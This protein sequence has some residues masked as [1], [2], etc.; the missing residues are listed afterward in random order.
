M[1]A[2]MEHLRNLGIVAHIDAGKTTVT[3]RILFYAGVEHRMGEV[4]E[5]T[6]VMDWME[7][8][9]RRGIT[10]T[11]AA[12]SVP[13]RDCLINLIDTPGHVDFT[14][15][16]ERSMRVLDGAI[17]V[18]NAVA[19]VQAQSE[20]V[21][22]QMQAHHVKS[23]AFVN[24]VDRLGAD[25]LRCVKDLEERLGAPAVPIQLPVGSGR[26]CRTIVDLVDARAITF[27]EE[28]NARVPV[29]GP[30]PSEVADEVGVLRAELI[31]A[32]AEEDEAVMGAFLEE[33]EP[34]A[35][36]LRA[37]LRRRVLA[38]TLMPVLCGAAL[39][40]VGIQPL[41]EA[42][43]DYL[44]APEEVPPIRGL[45]AG[46]GQPVERPHDPDAPLCALAFKLSA[47]PHEDL[48]YTRVY[49]GRIRPGQK[50]FNPRVKRMERVARV[51]RMHA[52]AR[53][54]LEEAGPGQIVAL[55]G[56]K[57]TVTG[58]TLCDH[59]HALFLERVRFPKPVVSRVVEPAST[60]DRDRLRAALERLAFEDPSFHVREKEDTG[61]WLIAGMGE[62]HLEVKEHLLSELYRVSVHAGQPRVEYRETLRGRARGSGKVDRVLGGNRVV[63]AVEL[64]LEPLTPPAG[65]AGSAPAAEVAWEA[66]CPVDAKAR[67][68]VE[69]ALAAGIQTGPRMGYPLEPLRIRVLSCQAGDPPTELGATLAATAALRQALAGADVLLL[70]PWMAFAIEA[71]AEFMSGIL[72]ELNSKRAQI[73]G[74]DVEAG[75]KRV[76]GRVPLAPMF[77]FAS[78]LRSLS[79]GRADFSLQPAGHEEVPEAEVAARGLV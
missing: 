52:D 21:W 49:S 75:L 50:V 62:L 24:Q 30:V 37:A 25:F 33:R 13:W 48:V 64:E 35:E 9:R 56:C 19:G 65:G 58:D 34:P 79:Q 23:L 66:E 40:N 36:L 44:P 12:T 5:G 17:L 59:D 77:G 22:R 6:A 69:E 38:G 71:P 76:H 28:D 39:R 31:E 78:T 16:V 61:Q 3:E 54:P 1:A 43:V 41:L 2:A 7:E 10:I 57:L 29:V 51:L 14:I 55:T 67:A 20:T 60:E 68:A 32:L 15:E 11:A 63:G 45:D 4:H 70:E 18:L 74:L 8:E 46:T 27:P 73:G 53:T 72:A 42:I 47:D 26:E